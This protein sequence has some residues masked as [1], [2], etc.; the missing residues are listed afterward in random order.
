LAE[1][2]N[3][4][5]ALGEEAATKELESLT[6]DWTEDRKGGFSTNERIGW[7]CR[8]LFQ[9]K[10]KEPLRAPAFVLLAATLVA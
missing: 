9:P 5:V 4:Y 10:G 8:I 2:A 3:H 7:I 1:A 6:S